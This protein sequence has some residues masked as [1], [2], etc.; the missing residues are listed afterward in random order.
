M[1]SAVWCSISNPNAGGAEHFGAGATCFVQP[2][3]GCRA[4]GGVDV[5]PG[6][7][8]F[9]YPLSSFLLTITLTDLLLLALLLFVDGMAWNGVRHSDSRLRS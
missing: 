9:K 4:R 1:E 3:N 8:V 7:S 5:G 2:S 6:A